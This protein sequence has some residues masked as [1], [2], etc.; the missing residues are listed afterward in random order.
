M[1]WE[2]VKPKQRCVMRFIKPVDWLFKNHH[3]RSN[4]HLSKWTES[5]ECEFTPHKLALFIT[6]ILWGG[7]N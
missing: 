3:M 6:N 1:Q 5:L 7:E 4:L 2:T